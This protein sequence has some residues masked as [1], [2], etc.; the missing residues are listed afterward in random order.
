MSDGLI[1]VIE[2]EKVLQDVAKSG[3]PISYAA[4]LGLFGFA[5]TRPKMRKLC[6][7]VEEVDVIARE[8]G[9]PELSPLVV[10]QSD[11]LPGE[12]W[13]NE[14]RFERMGKDRT[15]DE[16]DRKTIVME[17]QAFAFRHWSP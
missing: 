13:F 10:R 7:L 16:T 2:L 11:G 3:Q 15:S 8:K 17:A 12:G 9:E 5:F 6:N 4:L 1:D 14:R